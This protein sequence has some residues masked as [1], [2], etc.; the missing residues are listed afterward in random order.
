MKHGGENRGAESLAGNIRDEKRGAP[1]AERKN[2]EVI[3]TDRQAGKIES[4]DGEVRVFAEIARQKRLLNVA[5]DVDLL[6]EALAFTLAFHEAGIVQNVRSV[7]GQGIQDLAVELGEGGGAARPQVENAEE[8]SALD[9]D[10]RFLSVCACHVV[11][12]KL[13]MQQGTGFEQTLELN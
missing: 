13:R 4:R 2:I 8:F 12:G 6:L 11:E 9:V 7:G 5:G 3:S 10:H 1:V